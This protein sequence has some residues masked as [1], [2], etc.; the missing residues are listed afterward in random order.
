[1]A[2]RRSTPRRLTPEQELAA[3]EIRAAQLRRQIKAEQRQPIFLIGLDPRDSLG[4][5]LLG[6]RYQ[7][8]ERPGW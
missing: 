6:F 5:H 1:M 3:L 4:F 2:K 8:V 7:V